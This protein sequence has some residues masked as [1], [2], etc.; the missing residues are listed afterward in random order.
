M[1]ALLV[2]LLMAVVGC[3]GTGTLAPK[4]L[5]RDPIFDGAA[6]PAIIYSQAE[7]KWLMF[8]TMR[9]ANVAGLTAV[10][11][12]HGTPIGVAESTDGAH[13]AYRGQIDFP[14]NMP[15]DIQGK[16]SPATYWAPALLRHGDTY[17][18][19]LTMVPG[20]FNDW[21]HP[22]RIVHLTSADLKQWQYQSSLK[23]ASDKVIDAAVMQL[24]N[25]SWRLWYNNEAAAKTTFYADSQDLYHWVDKGSAKLP[26]DR[27]EAP[28]VFKWRGHYWLINDLLGNR[29][30]GV[31]KSSDASN[32]LRQPHDLLSQAGRGLDDQNGGHHPAVI[33]S[34]DRAY[35]YYFV[36]PGVAADSDQ[37]DSKRSSIQVV[38]LMLRDGW[39]R[40]D[41]DAPSYIELLPPELAR[42]D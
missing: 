33:V 12:V 41:R 13:W 26:Q 14:E 11:W 19:Y 25:G 27:G 36:H 22:R 3:T 23:L 37:A 16:D 31:Y 30:L 5:Y 34:G 4:P 32:W 24:P 15:P 28:L 10:S 42:H 38:E 39:L 2:L 21:N 6:D 17:H 1:R 18:M 7:G 20:I 29:G 9:R 8:H 40:A 35:L